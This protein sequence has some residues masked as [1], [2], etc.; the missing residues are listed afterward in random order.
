[1]SDDAS[2][3]GRWV[4]VKAGAGLAEGELR[5]AMVEGFRLCLGLTKDGR[6][7]ALDDGCPHA[8]GSLSQG[9][10]DRDEV[11]CPLHAWG[12][13]VETG[14]CAEDPRCPATVYPARVGTNGF[15]VQLP[16]DREGAGD[17]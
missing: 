6:A 9:M 5:G 2:S 4:L 14:A 1:M 8:G 16:S 12:F 10:L 11:V 13:H 17:A 15:E 7:F 3:D